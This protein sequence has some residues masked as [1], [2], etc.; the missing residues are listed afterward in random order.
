LHD[1]DV[2]RT[3]L[4]TFVVLVDATG[5]GG[6]D[7]GDAADFAELE[8]AAAASEHATST[9]SNEPSLRCLIDIPPD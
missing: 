8:H 5:D 2:S 6:V 9:V 7:V 3:G 1:A 4:G